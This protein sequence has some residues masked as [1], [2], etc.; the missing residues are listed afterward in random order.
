MTVLLTGS[1]LNM[2]MNE[3]H[4]RTRTIRVGMVIPP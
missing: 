1:L 2:I 3:T 4:G